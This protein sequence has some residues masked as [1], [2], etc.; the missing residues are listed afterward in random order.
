[1]GRLRLGQTIAEL[2]DKGLDIADQAVTD[3]DKLN[4]LKYKM[5][6]IRATALLTGKGQSITKITI[7]GLVTLVVGVLSYTYLIKPDDIDMAIRYSTAATP[8]I[9]VLIGVYGTAKTVQRKIR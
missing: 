6:E 2:A 1:M 4:E 7:C 5:E 8:I 9:G 3:K